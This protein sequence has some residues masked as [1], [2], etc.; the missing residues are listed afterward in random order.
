ML[1]APIFLRLFVRVTKDWS[2]KKANIKDF[3]YG[4]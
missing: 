2:K 4:D 3:G 1:G